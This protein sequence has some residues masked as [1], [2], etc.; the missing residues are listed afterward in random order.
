MKTKKEIMKE[1]EKNWESLSPEDKL[2]LT[3]YNNIDLYQINPVKM[4][5]SR[6][7][8]ILKTIKEG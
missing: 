1:I 3:I 5:K 4:K 2:L 8:E 7:E 6:L